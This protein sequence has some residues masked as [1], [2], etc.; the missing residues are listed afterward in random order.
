MRQPVARATDP[1]P[2]VIA[3]NHAPH[4]PLGGIT[5]AT[6][7]S[8]RKLACDVTLTGSARVV[9]GQPAQ[10][11]PVRLAMY[12]GNALILRKAV[13]GVGPVGANGIIEP[14]TE[15]P[16]TYERALGG[17][18]MPGNPVGTDKPSVRH[19]SEAEAPGCFAPIPSAWKVRRDRVEASLRERLETAVPEV[20]AKFDWEYFQE[21]PRDQVV[22][23]LEGGEWLLIEGVSR[24]MPR[25]QTQLPRLAPRAYVITRGRE[26]E[27]V[28]LAW[29][30]LAIDGESLRATAVFRADVASPRPFGAL[31]DVAIVI[32]LEGAD[33]M[34]NELPSPAELFDAARLVPTVGRVVS[35]A[36]TSTSS[37]SAADQQHAAEKPVAPYTLAVPAS[38][39]VPFAGAPGG[40]PRATPPPGSPWAGADAPMP[41]VHPA[42]KGPIA[43]TEEM[44]VPARDELMKALAE[45]RQ[46]PSTPSAMTSS[47]TPRFGTAAPPGPPPREGPPP[48]APERLAPPREAPTK[49]EVAKRASRLELARKGLKK[50]GM[51]E[52]RITEVLQQ[53]ER[54]L[55]SG[56]A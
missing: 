30:T 1:T 51:S 3:D 35:S 9:G 18:G 46:R 5:E 6:E 40:A 15:I 26:P 19:M 36:L 14:I 48:V 39:A 38:A 33:A 2:L 31:R 10:T 4:R 17:A 8:P 37:L 56:G 11:L 50:S 13:V 44:A 7:K 25:V 34:A 55:G 52:A 32:R 45:S 16:L 41:D 23:Y 28:H 49:E 29:D 42:P 12:R 24:V 53:I 47:G 22:S 27:A 54:E 43:R 21:A 20:P